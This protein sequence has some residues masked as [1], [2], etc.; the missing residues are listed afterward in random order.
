MENHHRLLMQSYSWGKLPDLMY[1][2]RYSI[3]DESA[4][5]VLGDLLMLSSRKRGGE[6][7][8]LGKE[9]SSLYT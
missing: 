4:D 1:D 7:P 2:V 6:R 5:W 3:G 8:K 9:R